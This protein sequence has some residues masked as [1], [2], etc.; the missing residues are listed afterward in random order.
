MQY[1]VGLGAQSNNDQFKITQLPTTIVFDRNGKI[2]D[3]FEGLTPFEKIEEAVRKNV[4]S[5]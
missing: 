2:V 5:N 1:P 4:Q 3:R